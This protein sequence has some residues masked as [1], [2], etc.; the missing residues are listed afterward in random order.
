M[1]V[2]PSYVVSGPPFI[3]I[4]RS[5]LRYKYLGIETVRKVTCRTTKSLHFFKN[6]PNNKIITF[7][8]ESYE[9]GFSKHG[10]PTVTFTFL[11]DS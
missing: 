4:S 10:S 5:A 7:S 9:H 1:T 11:R 3:K 6:K 8:T 2:T